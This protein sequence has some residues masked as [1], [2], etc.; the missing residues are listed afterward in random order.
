MKEK[1]EILVDNA[2]MRER[3]AAAIKDGGL[4]EDVVVI[5]GDQFS[6]I[7]SSETLGDNGGRFARIAKRR[8]ILNWNQQVENKRL[9]KKAAKPR[10]TRKNEMRR[11]REFIKK[12][13][14]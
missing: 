5:S 11:A 1:V 2:E 7:D 9:A 10:K 12:V 8:E 13:G 14:G 4:S 6:V 3:A